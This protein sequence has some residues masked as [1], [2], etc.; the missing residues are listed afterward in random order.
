MPRTNNNEEDSSQVRSLGFGRR[1]D[2]HTRNISLGT[3]YKRIFFYI[4]YNL[5]IPINFP[6][7]QE[8]FH[9]KF[10]G[11][12][13]IELKNNIADEDVLAFQK[14][15]T[16]IRFAIAGIIYV[17]WVIW[18][19]NFWLLLGLPIL[20][21]IYIFKKVNWAFWKKREGKN[22]DRWKEHPLQILS[23]FLPSTGKNCKAATNKNCAGIHWRP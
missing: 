12:V 19:S 9:D 5:T 21:D 6:K 23:R 11:S 20:A 10:S 22:K 16:K 13:L 1:F 17:L 7:L 4:F 15:R 14:Q 3:A 2:D 18:V 8:L